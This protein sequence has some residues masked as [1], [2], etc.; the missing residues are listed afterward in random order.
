MHVQEQHININ[1]KFF[2]SNTGTQGNF[3]NLS[4]TP[5]YTVRTACMSRHSFCYYSL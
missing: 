1:V 5:A 2:P 4:R 3:C